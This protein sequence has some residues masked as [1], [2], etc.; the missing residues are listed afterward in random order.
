MVTWNLKKPGLIK[1]ES[2]G[3]G[4]FLDSNSSTFSNSSD[5]LNVQPELR[6]SVPCCTDMEL[7]GF[8]ING[9]DGWMSGWMD[10][11]RDA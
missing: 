6:T 2:L 7:A 8:Y 11:W 10:G 1:S 4:P 3:E 5:N 9:M